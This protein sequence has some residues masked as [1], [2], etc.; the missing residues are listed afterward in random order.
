MRYWTFVLII[1][2]EFLIVAIAGCGFHLHC[3]VH[4][5]DEMQTMILNS[6]D[7]YSPLTRA[8]R[9]KL[10]LNGIILID[11]VDS[12]NASLPLLRIINA[13]ESQGITSVFQNGKPAERQL[14]LTVQAQVF[15]PGKYYYPIEIIVSRS[16][17]DHPLIVLAK[18]AEENIIRQEMHQQAAQQLVCKLLSA[19]AVEQTDNAVLLEVPVTQ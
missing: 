2:V 7:P 18:D 15:M 19:H 13:S 3:N 5:P 17:F 11:D 12:S 8:I 9:V 4:V 10:L 14:I 16:F 1:G 6:Y